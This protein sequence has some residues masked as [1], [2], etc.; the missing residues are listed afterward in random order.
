MERYLEDGVE[1]VLNYLEPYRI[2]GEPSNL[3]LRKE[4]VIDTE[5]QEKIRVGL[6]EIDSFDID[7]RKKRV[8]IRNLWS[9][10]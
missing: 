9:I 10:R 7:S 5:D 3:F 1:V 8:A 2:E 4:T 6:T